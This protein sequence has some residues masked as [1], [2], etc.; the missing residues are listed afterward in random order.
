MFCSLRSF[1]GK[2]T[3]SPGQKKPKQNKKN[4]SL[5]FVGC[6]G[7]IYTVIPSSVQLKGGK[8]NSVTH[9]RTTTTRGNTDLHSKAGGH[10]R[11]TLLG[12]IAQRACNGVECS[13]WPSLCHCPRSSLDPISST[14]VQSSQLSACKT[15]DSTRLFM[16]RA[17]K[18]SDST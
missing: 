8:P 7:T 3:V 9:E 4:F 16:T 15:S 14:F 11:H 13:C 17:S 10:D 18:I 12:H 2:R 5:S 1:V 6:L